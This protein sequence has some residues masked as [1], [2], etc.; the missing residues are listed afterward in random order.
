VG[1]TAFAADLDATNNAVAYSL[2]DAAG[3]A[4]T[5]G[6]FAI[7]A[8]TGVVTV[9]GAIDRDSGVT[10]TLF[11]K[12]LSADGSSAITSFTLDLAA[13]V[14]VGGA[15]DDSLVGHAGNDTLSGA[16]GNDTLVGGAGNDSMVG[17]AGDDVYDVD[18]LGDVLVE[19]L[20]EGVDT[21]RTALSY[22][23]A[24]AFENLVLTGSDPVSGTGNEA[25]NVVTG[26]AG[27][28]TLSGLAGDDTLNGG[29]GSDTLIGGSGTNRLVGGTGD[30]LYVVTSAT[31]TIV[32][33]AGEG[34][35]RLWAGV[36]Y[37]LGSGVSVETLSLTGA[38]T[39][40]TGN[41]LANT[42]YGGVLNDTL[43]G[44]GGNDLMMGGLGNDSLIGGDG[45]DSLQGG[46]GNDTLAGGSGANQLVGGAGDDLYLVNSSSDVISEAAGQGNDRVWAGVNYVL[47]T[48]ASVETVALMGSATQATGNELA[49]ALLGGGLS[50]L[51][52]G[53]GGNDSLVGAGGSDTLN[54]GDGNDTLDGGSGS[55]L[56]VG[57]AGDDLFLINSSSDVISEATGQGNDR[58][59]ASVNFTLTAGASVET[60]ALMG[61][62]TQLAGNEQANALLGGGL[63]DTLSGMAGNDSLSGFAGNDQLLGGSGND[64]LLGGE[65][66]DTLAGGAGSDSLV[67]GSG[68]DVFVMDAALNAANNVDRIADFA[69]GDRI[70]LSAAV[71][72]A[73]SAGVGASLSSTQFYSG[74]GLTG[75]T[76]VAQGAG[77][78]YNTTDGSLHYDADGFGHAGAVQFAIIGQVAGHVPNLTAADFIIGS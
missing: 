65:G 41:E 13:S 21:V 61:S 20:N 10:R 72:S 54:G 59:W 53:L 9:A 76:S 24:T 78:Y 48:G 18:S 36:N 12:A 25:D 75:S 16:A 28:N 62:A 56:L 49:N 64:T 35:D 5:G 70:Q 17:G 3:Q 1:L 34:A 11:V 74:A 63:A 32:E 37:T 47:G 22:T 46:A 26:N 73:L 4:Y 44:L 69:A 71:F 67:G 66:S 19:N 43:S 23:L 31:D 50:D 29:A 15:G 6:E 57:G 60:L 38:A 42:V 45:N 51:L 27:N 7:D 8:G 33:A 14:L 77:V 30:D 39:A 58:V 2:V 68:R 55:N 52:R 40:L